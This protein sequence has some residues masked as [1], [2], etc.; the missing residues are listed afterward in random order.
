MNTLREELIVDVSFE[1][2]GRD[3]YLADSKNS[4]R[5]GHWR[6]GKAPGRSLWMLW[7]SCREEG[8]DTPG[9][10]GPRVREGKEKRTGMR[11]DHGEPCEGDRRHN[12]LWAR[13]DA[14]PNADLYML[15]TNNKYWKKGTR[16]TTKALT[17]LQQA[18]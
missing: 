7:T 10:R 13:M 18:T 1:G 8:V 11:T 17:S 3:S 16:T 2:R 14:W 12:R 4:M 15:V 9:R 6:N 5:E